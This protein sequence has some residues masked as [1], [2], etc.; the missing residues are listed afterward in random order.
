MT[1]EE[2]WPT[3]TERRITPLPRIQFT[4][5]YLPRTLTRLNYNSYPVGRK[6]MQTTDNTCNFLRPDCRMSTLPPSKPIAWKVQAYLFNPPPFDVRNPISCR[7]SARILED[8]VVGLRLLCY[9]TDVRTAEDLECRASE[10]S[11]CSLDFQ[12]ANDKCVGWQSSRWI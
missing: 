11:R 10:E 5:T 3:G 2:N 4:K 12:T 7:S 8:T 6:S 1:A 9:L